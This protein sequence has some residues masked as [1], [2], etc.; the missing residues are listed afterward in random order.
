M[1]FFATSRVVRQISMVM[2]APE[3]ASIGL[4]S[5]S[6][7]CLVTFISEGSSLVMVISPSLGMEPS[8]VLYTG[9]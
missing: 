6:V 7:H 2:L 5:M 8:V 1:A 3:G 9:M 4:P